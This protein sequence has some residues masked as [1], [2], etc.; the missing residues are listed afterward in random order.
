M[1]RSIHLIIL[2]LVLCSVNS[3]AQSINDSTYMFK[4]RAIN[5][6]DSK[7]GK[8]F[9]KY[10]N[11][12]LSFPVNSHIITDLYGNGI[13][14]IN[15][16]I[17]SL[18]PCDTVIY[19]NKFLKSQK[20]MIDSCLRYC[21]RNN[22]KIDSDLLTSINEKT[23][24]YWIIDKANIDTVTT[25]NEMFWITLAKEYIR[26]D[27]FENEKYPIY[28]HG[29]GNKSFRITPQFLSTI[30]STVPT[31]KTIE[32]TLPEWSSY[33]DRYEF[34]DGRKYY[35]IDTYQYKV[36][37]E[38]DKKTAKVKEI[39]ISRLSLS[40]IKSFEQRLIGFG[41][42]LNPKTSDLANAIN[43]G[44]GGWYEFYSKKGS[45]ITFVLKSNEI[46]VFKSNF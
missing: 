44:I 23:S 35:N 46:K 9:E 15:D 27:K 36:S 2:A 45:K 38:Y 5:L 6:T 17:P 13:N 16:K 34:E 19:K 21:N 30:F 1:K 29:L 32:S 31:L 8:N 43:N 26:K 39:K 18:F 7:Y 40:E 10:I 11:W 4:E 14:R 12:I 37:V 42:I 25:L 3:Y 28:T 24:F 20:Q 41:Y 22:I 33:Q